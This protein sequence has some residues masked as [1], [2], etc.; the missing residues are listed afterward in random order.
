MNFQTHF[1]EKEKVRIIVTEKQQ[2]LQ[3]SHE[4]IE[5]MLEGKTAEGSFIIEGTEGKIVKGYITCPDIRMVYQE[6]YFE[7]ESI[8]IRYCF[9]GTNVL[10]GEYVKGSFAVISECGEY[11][12]PFIVMREKKTLNSSMGEIRNLFHFTNLARTNWEEAVKLFFEPEFK[13]ILTGSDSEYRDIYRGLSVRVR[14]QYVEEFLLRVRKKNPVTYIVDKEEV[15]LEN[16]SEVYTEEVEIRKN[17]WGYTF[18][19]IELEGDFLSVEKDVLWNDDFQENRCRLSF[20]I[21]PKNLHYGK[22]WGKILL[23]HPY[24]CIQIT[25]LVHQHGIVKTNLD[26]Q[27]N[28]KKYIAMMIENYVNFRCKKI[29]PEQWK[30]RTDEILGRLRRTDERNTLVRLFE[31]HI[32]ISK[33]SFVEAKGLLEYAFQYIRKEKMPVYYGYYLY[34]FSFLVK[35]E[36]EQKNIEEEVAN[37]YDENE[38]SWQLAW[39][40]MYISQ[41]LRTDAENRWNFLKERFQENCFSP[42]MYTEAVLLLNYQPG[43][44]TELGNIELRI[45]FFGQKKKMLSKEVKSILQSL[46]LRKKEYSSKICQLLMGICEDGTETEMLQALCSLLI[47]GNKIGYRYFPWYEKAVEEGLKLTRLYEYYMMSM[48]WEQNRKISDAVLL[49]FSYQ[50]ELSYEYAACLYR[51]IYERR[52]LMPELYQAYEPG[53]DRFLL[54]QLYAGKINRNLGYLYEHILLSKLNTEDNACQLAKILFTYEADRQEAKGNKLIVIHKV[55][56]EERVYESTGDFRIYLYNDNHSL[57]WE[58][59]WGYRFV[60]EPNQRLQPFLNIRKAVEQIKGFV[61]DNLGFALHCSSSARDWHFITEENEEQFLY[62]SENEKIKAEERQDIRIRLLEYYYDEDKMEQLDSCLQ[63][64]LPDFVRKED[65]EKLIHYLV[66]RGYYE[67]AY[68]F[69]R[70]YGPENMISK[71][72]IRVCDYL[73]EQGYPHDILLWYIYTA[74]QKGKCNE[75]MLEYLVTNYCGTSKTMRDIFQTA[76]YFG[77][78]TYPISE[79]IL[80]QLLYTK[81]YIGNEAHIFKKYISRGEQTSLATDFLL[82]CAEGYMLEDKMIDSFFMKEIAR[83]HQQ[84]ISFPM[85]VHLAYLRYFAENPRERKYADKKLIDEFLQEILFDKELLF[86][87]LQ[88]YQDR[89]GM[90]ILT[91]KTLLSYK[92][93]PGTRVVLHYMRIFGEEPEESFQKEEMK[94]VYAGVFVKDFILFFGEEIQYYI[95]EEQ[96]NKEEL[97]QSGRIQKEDNT[98]IA[99]QSR[100]QMIYEMSIGQTME[101][102]KTVDSLL[103]EYWKMEYISEQVFR[104]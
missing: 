103:E 13:E 51:Y 69:I 62:I 91:D 18:F 85:I 86:P 4:S 34:L 72:F 67:R 78:D 28:T 89:P 87:F 65:R 52:E 31:A 33:E 2:T 96:E 76:N 37:L 29:E 84:G 101:D 79:R 11:E 75:V 9:D 56:K 99:G 60:W 70:I 14:E 6:E 57:F 81:A 40:F 95:T 47:K 19:R 94:E 64:Y 32:Q 74:F 1:R 44:L 36:E 104:I 25:V 83:V 92:T 68:D 23:I 88:E 82:Y 17:N 49:Y 15:F 10:P 71:A 59:K 54:K 5:L 66:I 98:E 58:D 48:D 41:D 38:N 35:D 77:V 39:I 8:E 22:N 102:Y 45:L 63:E 53:I 61:K 12:I 46:V 24:G 50:R 97:T 93:E 7:G 26:I 16:I 80:N 21:H 73:L 20:S 100:Y 42:V 3:F 43:L 27:R 30:T 90:E 55:L